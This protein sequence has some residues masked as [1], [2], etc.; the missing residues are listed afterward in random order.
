MASF[1]KGQRLTH[2]NKWEVYIWTKWLDKHVDEYFGYTYDVH[3]GTPVKIPE[4][5]PDWMKQDTD[6]LSSKR[7][8]VVMEDGSAIYV[9]EI[10]ENATLGCL[11]TILSYRYLYIETFN[12]T[13]P[14]H[15]ILVTDK[16][17]P[18]LIPILDSLAI[19]YF[20]V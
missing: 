9:V 3:V 14:V 2:L 6:A 4:D 15:L 5:W 16:M 20:I 11:G 19:R 10:K 7:I 17:D 13:K 8:D 12:P 18:D 1:Y